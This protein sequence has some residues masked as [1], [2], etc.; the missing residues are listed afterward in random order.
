MRSADLVRFDRLATSGRTKPLIV[1]LETGDG[2]RHEA[3][4][5]LPNRFGL[6]AQSV[7]NEYLGA[8]LAQQVGVPLC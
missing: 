3:Y 5:K 1:E 6:T 2:E 4:L 8:A 7:F